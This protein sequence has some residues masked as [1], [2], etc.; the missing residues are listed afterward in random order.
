MSIEDVNGDVGV[1]NED[2]E[3]EMFVEILGK[4]SR[5]GVK[6]VVERSD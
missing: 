6:R 2:V 4:I 3:I 5:K 1:S